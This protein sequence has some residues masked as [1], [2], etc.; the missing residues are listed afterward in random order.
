MKTWLAAWVLIFSTGLFIA[1]IANPAERRK[2]L[3]IAALMLSLM[4]LSGYLVMFR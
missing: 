2:N 4:A 1:A 3:G